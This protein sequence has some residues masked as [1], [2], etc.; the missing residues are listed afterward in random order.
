MKNKTVVCKI[1]T[2][3]DVLRRGYGLIFCGDELRQYIK[4]PAGLKKCTLV[5]SSTPN[6]QNWEIDDSG[7]LR[8]IARRHYF[9]NDARRLLREQRADGRP[10]VHIEY[11][12]TS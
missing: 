8:E 7:R 6:S 5:F 1:N 4:L 11:E 9:M 2:H 10:Y 12:V 3:G